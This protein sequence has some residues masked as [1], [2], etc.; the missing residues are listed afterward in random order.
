MELA[1]YE[2][3]RRPTDRRSREL[4][5]HLARGVLDESEVS[6]FDSLVLGRD[7]TSLASTSRGGSSSP[8]KNGRRVRRKRARSGYLSPEKSSSVDRRYT[9]SQRE[10]FSVREEVTNLANESV[11]M[12]VKE[13]KRAQMLSQRETM[14]AYKALRA[15]QVNPSELDLHKYINKA[16]DQLLW[17]LGQ[18]CPHV[19]SL[20][21]SGW[22]RVSVASLRAVALGFGERLLKIDLSDSPLDDEMVSMLTARFFCLT[23]LVFRNCQKLTNGA[24]RAVAVGTHRS[25]TSLD[26]SDCPVMTEDALMWIAGVSGAASSA[27]AVLKSIS[28]ENCAGIR[29]KGLIALGQQCKRLQYVNISGCLQVTD[30]GL[31]GLALGCHNLRVLHAA[32]CSE[33][34]DPALRALGQSCIKL[35]SVNFSRCSRITDEGLRALCQD[36]TK[37]QALNLAGCIEVSE[38]GIYFVVRNNKALQIL[39]VTGCELIS[40]EGLQQMLR[41]LQFVE[42]AKSYTGFKPRSKAAQLKLDAQLQIV[43]DD[44]S[45]RISAFIRAHGTRLRLKREARMRLEFNAA[46]LIQRWIRGCFGRATYVLMW[47]HRQQLQAALLVQRVW[48]GHTARLIRAVRLAQLDWERKNTKYAV[49]IQAA[50]RGAKTREANPEVVA[51]IAQ[52]KEDRWEEAN[53]AAV[54]RI[55]AVVR[56]RISNVLNAARR[57]ELQQRSRDMEYAS[58]HIQAVVRRRLAYLRMLREQQRFKRKYAKQLRAATAIQRIARG[59]IGRRIYRD[60][61]REYALEQERLRAAACH[62][63]R[64]RR[65]YLGRLAFQLRRQEHLRRTAAATQIQ[66]LIRSKRVPPWRKLRFQIVRDMVKSRS[67]DAHQKSQTMV[68]RRMYLRQLGLDRDSASGDEHIRELGGYVESDD[69]DDW[70]EHWDPENQ[71]VFYFSPSRNL[72]SWDKFADDEFEQSLVGHFVRVLDI[73]LQKW[74]EGLVASYNRKKQKHRVEF[75]EYIAAS[76]NPDHVWLHFKED[77]TNIQ[78]YD[79]DYDTWVMF[80]HVRIAYLQNRPNHDIVEPLGTST[81]SAASVSDVN[82]STSE[83]SQPGRYTMHFDEEHQLQYYYDTITGETMWELPPGVSQDSVV[84]ASPEYTTY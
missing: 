37:L 19:V 65:G 12:T 63:Q 56:C 18:M 77:E 43:Q 39:N 83:V 2:R 42:L 20:N 21:L 59:M 17:E 9:L 11:Y 76:F 58:V 79:P 26:I 52:L 33:I 71:R 49:K 7:N 3:A 36:A 23:H 69:D 31:E 75:Y 45:C 47:L 78:I 38:M 80:R 57:E 46:S 34:G 41:G 70:Q 27:C 82:A 54:V 66:S 55:Q 13:K 60:R 1:A 28:V 73:S 30:R 5:I 81:L 62:I 48:R 35:R 53:S 16:K 8:G 51:V 72:R 22:K 32:A 64:M 25:L 67:D 74:R 6:E 24:L 44:A 50:F 14:E 15:E 84:T 40:Q 61:M 10:E 68:V 29:D 4:A